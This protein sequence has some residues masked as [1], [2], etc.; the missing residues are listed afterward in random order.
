MNKPLFLRSNYLYVFGL[1]V[2]VTGLPLSLFLISISQFILTGSFFLEGNFIA[3]FK[4]FFHNKAA[5]LVAGIWLMHVIGLIWTS[6]L[7]Q[8]WDDI[9][10]KLPLLVLTVIMA[11]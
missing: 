8:G 5:L 9:R 11:G 1:I 3:K 2:L 7:S 6:N 10:I 4:R